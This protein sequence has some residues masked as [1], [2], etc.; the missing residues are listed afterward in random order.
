VHSRTSD[1]CLRDIPA[2]RFGRYNAAT[3]G[4]ERKRFESRKINERLAS[5]QPKARI[6]L[7]ISD[8]R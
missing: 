3:K 1:V 4:E 6:F 7:D 8:S 2:I 5:G